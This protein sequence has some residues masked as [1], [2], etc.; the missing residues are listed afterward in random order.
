MRRARVTIVALEKQCIAYSECVL[1]LN[2]FDS[3]SKNTQIL[4]CMKIRLVEA[5][6]TLADGWTNGRADK[7]ADMTKLIVSFPN[8]ANEPKKWLELF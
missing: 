8:F 7:Q 1:N 2:V 3:F 6:L 4:K 5:E